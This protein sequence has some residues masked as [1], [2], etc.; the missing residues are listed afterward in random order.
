MEK[1]LMLFIALHAGTGDHIANA[2]RPSPAQTATSAG[3]GLVTANADRRQ[4]DSAI[5]KPHRIGRLGA[6]VSMLS[7]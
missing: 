7:P 4:E 1:A 2:V 5:K 6:G 3:K